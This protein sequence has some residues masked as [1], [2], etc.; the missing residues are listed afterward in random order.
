MVCFVISHAALASTLNLIASTLWRSSP[1]SLETQ[2]GENGQAANLL[3]VIPRFVGR[4][5]EQENKDMVV[6]INRQMLAKGLMVGML[7]FSVLCSL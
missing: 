5:P 2:L 4:W 1:A 6:I 7:A 3:S